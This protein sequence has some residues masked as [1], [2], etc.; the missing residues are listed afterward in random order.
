MNHLTDE[1][2]VMYYYGEGDGAAEVRRHLDACEACRGQYANLQ[3]VLNIV[4]SAPVPE[5][6]ANYGAQ[7]WR[8]LEPKLDGG[9]G[10]RARW[11]APVRWPL[12]HWTAVAAMAAL[13]V[14][15][16]IAGRHYPQPSGQMSA[17]G[18][19]RERILLVAV[20]D[21]LERSQMVLVE[22]VNARPGE[23]LDISSEQQR[24]GNLVAENRLYRQTAAHSGDAR[25]A[26]VLDELEPVLL[27][28]ANGPAH[29][30]PEQVDTL[31]QRIQGDGIL[32]KVRVVGSSV[33]QREKKVTAGPGQKS[34]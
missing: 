30:T 9:R 3:R 14:A 28:I 27:A 33:R 13:V 25:V 22:L 29:L 23:A 24:A 15:A 20:G 17:A 10:L 19:V 8:K 32:F 2:F 31:R 7:V 4:D 26:G 16:F 34:L 18:Q 21:H 5:R 12:R 6:A 11:L 1:Q